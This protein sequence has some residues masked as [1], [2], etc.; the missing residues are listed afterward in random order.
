ME[1]D[2]QKNVED[3]KEA[4]SSAINEREM[5]EVMERVKE[6]MMMRKARRIRSE[7]QV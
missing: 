5:E 1:N 3:K 2:K 6:M 4:V 7:T